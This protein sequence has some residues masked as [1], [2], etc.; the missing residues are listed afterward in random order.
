MKISKIGTGGV[1][2]IDQVKNKPEVKRSQYEKKAGE[3]VRISVKGEVERYKEMIRRIPEVRE[4]KVRQIREAILQGNY[5]IEPEK[6]SRR[7]IED[8]ILGA[9]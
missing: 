2:N 9:K 5:R 6:V 3:Q 1:Y 4:E 7:M 8:F